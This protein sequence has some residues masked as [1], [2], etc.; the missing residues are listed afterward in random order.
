MLRHRTS[1]Q[2]LIAAAVLATA[3]IPTAAQAQILTLSREQMIK[4]TSLNPYERFPDGRPKVPESLLQKLRDMSAE[5]FWP[6]ARR[7]FANQYADGFQILHPEKFLI[8]R[9]FT[10]QFLPIRQDV[11][12]V[13]AA[14]QKAKGV[15][16]PFNHQSAIDMLQE[17]DVFVADVMGQTAAGGI[18][19]DNLAYYIWKTTK[20][21]FVIDGAIR[22]LDGIHPFDMGGYFR[23]AVPPAINNVMVSGV[24]VP[25]KIGQA[26]VMPGDVVFG[27]REGV[28]FVPPHLLQELVDDAHITHIHDVWTKKKFDEGKYKSTDIYG[29]PHDPALIKEYEDYLKAQ[30]G[31]EAYEA[32]QKRMRSFQGGPQRK[33]Q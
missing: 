3:L 14:D 2:A 28:Y 26:V 9:A 33:K 1:P 13:Y 29:R 30:I 22:D 31:A 25:I 23:A 8:G 32:Y 12:D 24:N 6:I 7:G 21:G 16:L 4:Y 15:S 10:V 5:E 11:T 19:G 18:I 20:R 17:G 27:D